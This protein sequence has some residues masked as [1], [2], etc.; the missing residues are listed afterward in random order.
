MAVKPIYWEDSFMKRKNLVGLLFVSSSLLVM[1][2]SFFYMIKFVHLSI[3]GITSGRDGLH[4]RM[5]NFLLGDGFP[6]GSLSRYSDS[7]Y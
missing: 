6:R 1:G 7:R 2:T 5:Y 3:L 4:N